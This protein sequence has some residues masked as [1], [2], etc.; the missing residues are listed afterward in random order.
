MFESS[1]V[2]DDVCNNVEKKELKDF[3]KEFFRAEY[4]IG[5]LI[6]ASTVYHNENIALYKNPFADLS[7]QPPNA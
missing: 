7:I 5:S 6:A 2:E 1:F 4:N 3:A